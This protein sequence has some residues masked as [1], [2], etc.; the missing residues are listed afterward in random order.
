M[1]YLPISVNGIAR[2]Q[3]A[4]RSLA[5]LSSIHGRCHMNRL[6]FG[7]GLFLLT[8]TAAAQQGPPD[9]GVC[10]RSF[11]MEPWIQVDAQTA[12]VNAGRKSYL[13][14]VPDCDSFF[15][16]LDAGEVIGSNGGRVCAGSVIRYS[17]GGQY[18]ET[19]TIT[20]IVRYEI[21][22]VTRAVQLDEIGD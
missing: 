13:V 19:C 20:D 16:G 6:I 22:P 11:Q 8:A 2:G 15:A 17:D 7:L 5:H 18:I 1:A 21:D 14:T 9:K 10:F 4:R 3:T 12:I